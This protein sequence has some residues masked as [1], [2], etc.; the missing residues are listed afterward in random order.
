MDDTPTFLRVA[1][2]SKTTLAGSVALD[3]IS[4][5]N[6]P[7]AVGAKSGEILLHGGTKHI[8]AWVHGNVYAGADPDTEYMRGSIHPTDKPQSLLTADGKIFGKMHP[9]YENLR[10]SDIVSIKAC[11]AKGDGKTDDTMAIQA[12]LTKVRFIHLTYSDTGG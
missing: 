5:R 10:A 9:Q 3:N 2:T 1:E 11:G 6:V 8:D 4:L 7:I 12:A